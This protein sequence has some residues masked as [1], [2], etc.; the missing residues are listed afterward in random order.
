MMSCE[1]DPG[2]VKHYARCREAKEQILRELGSCFFRVS[3]VGLITGG[4][5]MIWYWGKNETGFASGK[6]VE[7]AIDDADRKVFGGL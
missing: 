7:E 2:C 4:W 6:T 1:N 5:T 3:Y